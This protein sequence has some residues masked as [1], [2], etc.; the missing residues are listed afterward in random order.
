MQGEARLCSRLDFPCALGE[1]DYSWSSD[2]PFYQLVAHW[3]I[4]K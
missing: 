1:E 3:V 4:R 2:F